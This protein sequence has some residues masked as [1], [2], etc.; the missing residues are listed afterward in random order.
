MSAANNGKDGVDIFKGMW[1]NTDTIY[2]LV[3]L[4]LFM[5]LMGI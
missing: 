4:Y 5:L 2:L 3:L 1:E